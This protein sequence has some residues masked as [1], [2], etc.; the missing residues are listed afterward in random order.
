MGFSNPLFA[1]G[2]A[3]KSSQWWGIGVRKSTPA[4]IVEKLNKEINAALSDPS[5]KAR[6]ADLG[7]TLFAGSPADL[8]KFLVDDTARWAKVVKLSG[9]RSE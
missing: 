1:Q 8:E 9:A 5:I 3:K 7:S 4:E 2:T 6:L